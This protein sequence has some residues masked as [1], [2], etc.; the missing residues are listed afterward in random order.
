MFLKEEKI[1]LRE[2]QDR[3][4]EAD[5]KSVLDYR[6]WIQGKTHHTFDNTRMLGIV[7]TTKGAE[8]YLPYTIPKI[9]QQ[10]SEIGMMADIVIGLN[11][12]FECPAVIDQFVLLSDVQI[13]HLYTGEKLANNIPAPIFDNVMCQ[14]ESYYLNNMD[15]LY[16]RHRIFVL[17]QK[18]GQYSAGKIRVLGDIYGSLLL[19]SIENGWIPPALL[20]AF[21]AESIF[22]V[23]QNYSVIEPESNGLKLI[24][25]HLQN[26]SKIAILGTRN[27]FA[28][29]QKAIV[30]GSEILL[31]NFSE[32]LS[33]IHWFLDI[34]HGRFN[35]YRYKPASGTV[36]RTDA[37]IS[38]IAV[39][40]E[41][42][43]GIK[44][45]DTH[46]TILAK[47]AGF[48][49]DIF[50]DVI[51]TNRTPSLDDMTMEQPPK[52]AWKEQLYRWNT[53]NQGLKLL[54]GEHNIKFIVS[55]EFPWFTLIQ[56]LKFCKPLIINKKINLYVKIKKLI[57]LAIAFFIWQKISNRS[58]DN[59]DMLQGSKAQAFW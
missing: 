11:N 49:G 4:L 19:K 28:V 46:I 50:M 37:L 23:N 33:P 13:I 43:P 35:G 12:G 54:Y 39:I 29:Y 40:A 17:H 25:N 31:P 18:Q 56:P 32:E 51:S 44:S 7:A 15:K 24:V 52:R 58:I 38:I 1:T 21:D 42:Y 47:C 9:I 53:A 59:P 5:V 30:N 26:H 55:Y 45:D 16:C 22:L 10:I 34:V 3:T 20:V 57:V 2:K 6:A 48:I 8:N 36:G 41:R 27:K 14:G